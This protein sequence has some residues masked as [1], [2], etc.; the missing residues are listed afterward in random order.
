MV[1]GCLRAP[2]IDLR[3]ASWRGAP[4]SRRRA[5]TPGLS[6]KHGGASAAQLLATSGSARESGEFSVI[7][8]ARYSPVVLVLMSDG[9]LNRRS[10]GLARA[11]AAVG[12]LNAATFLKAS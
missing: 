5:G 12:Q 3:R 8:F 1:R 6:A 2:A 7:A 9:W 11:Q 4:L 10:D